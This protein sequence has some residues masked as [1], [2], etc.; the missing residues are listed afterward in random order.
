MKALKNIQESVKNF[1]EEYRSISQD[2]FIKNLKDNLK[3]KLVKE[4]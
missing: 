3:S 1:E 2:E 4:K